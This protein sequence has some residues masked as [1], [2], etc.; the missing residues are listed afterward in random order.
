MTIRH[1]SRGAAGRAATSAADGGAPRLTR[2][3]PRRRPRPAATPRPAQA[4]PFPDGA[5][6]HWLLSS[7]IWLTVVDLFGLVLATEFVTPEAFGGIS[8]LTFSRIRPSHVNG[9]ILAWLTMM[10]FGALFYMLPRLVGTRGDVERAARRHLVRWAWNLM[11]LLGDHRPAD[12]SQPGPRVRRVHLADRH[13]AARHLVREHRQHP[14]DGLDPDDQADL[15]LRLVLHREPALARGGL[16]DRQRD[17]AAGA[18]LGRAVRR[19]RGQPLRR[20]P[21]LVVRAQPLRALADADAARAHVL[22]RPARHQHAALQLHAVAHQ[23]LGDGVLLH[24]RRRPPHPAVADT[25]VAE[26]DRRGLVVDAARPGLRVHDQHPRNDEGQLG[27]SSSRT[28]RC[29]SR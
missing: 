23:L 26:D 19:A 17:L 22:H 18:H 16:R 3:A 4:D 7:I 6:K 15:R 29:D 21:Q 20:D 8:W 13:R 2:E 24:R 27:R 1:L 28:S 12:R 10:Y 9:V 5:A 11:F 25:G 14:R